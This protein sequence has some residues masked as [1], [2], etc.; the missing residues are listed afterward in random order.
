MCQ[1]DIKPNELEEPELRYSGLHG[2]TDN[3]G[4]S[5]L[6]VKNQTLEK[7]KPDLPSDKLQ[8]SDRNSQ[9]HPVSS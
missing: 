4:N 8:E 7:S 3:L 5:Y 6:D 2:Y 1:T 9:S